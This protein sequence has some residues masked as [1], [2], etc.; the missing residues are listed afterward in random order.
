MC[1]SVFVCDI[2]ISDRFSDKIIRTEPIPT[3]LLLQ[4]GVGNI[5]FGSDFFSFGLGLD[6]LG[7]DILYKIQ[8]R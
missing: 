1:V 5:G 3:D 4:V 8:A 2:R 7:Y 6:F